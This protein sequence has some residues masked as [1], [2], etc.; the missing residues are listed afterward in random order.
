MNSKFKNK[1]EM[2]KYFAG[3]ANKYPSGESLSAEH[4]EEVKS[5]LEFH[6]N[7]IEK[8]KG[9]IKDI[10]VLQDKFKN[11]GFNI[12]KDNGE[13]E[14][15]SFYKCIFG[16]KSR[17]EFFRQA[18]RMAIA[19][20]IITFKQEYFRKHADAHNEILCPISNEYIGWFDCH[21][22][23][24]SPKFRDIV[25][26]FITENCLDLQSVEFESV[27]NGYGSIFSD[28]KLQENFVIYHKKIAKLRIIKKEENMSLH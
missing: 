1:T 7:Y 10:I 19:D 28:K 15:F 20:D 23:H 18:G 9:G 26:S 11:K 8:I 25:N 14:N 21:V 2:R 24:E 4:F 22:D 5:L 3:I 17:I 6:P 16:E 13:L 12:I 27:S